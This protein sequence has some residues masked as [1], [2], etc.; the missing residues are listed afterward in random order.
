MVVMAPRD[1]ARVARIRRDEA[2]GRISTVTK[3]VGIGILTA[4]GV[5]GL[6]LSKALPGHKTTQGTSSV[7]T[8]TSSN[9]TSTSGTSSGSGQLAPPST[10]PVQAQ[11]PAPVVSGAS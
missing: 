5:L 10:P 1:H 11:Q 9:G 3:T 8:N 2:I 7:A 4:T 6:Y